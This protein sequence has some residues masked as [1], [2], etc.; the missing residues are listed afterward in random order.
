[1]ANLI[2][3]PTSGGS[4]I[5]QDEGGTAAHTIDST[6][7]TT[8]AD[9]A[10]PNEYY[11]NLKTGGYGA[12]ANEMINNSG[13]TLPYFTAGV[14]DTTNIAAVNNHDFKLVRAGIYL[15][16]VCASWYNTTTNS[17][18]T[19]SIS[20]RHNASSPTASEGTDV[21]ANN[22]GQVASTGSHNDYGGTTCNVVHNFSANH[23]INFYMGGEGTVLYNALSASI[24]LIRPF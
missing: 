7:K 5:L 1:M 18:R 22:N 10:L 12:I 21:L 14:G 16:T 3:K 11:L 8:I 13:S 15:I 2:I 9:I 19:V 20:V 23:L 6:G 17:N 4:L 24:V